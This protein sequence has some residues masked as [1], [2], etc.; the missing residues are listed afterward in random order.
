[1]TE[2]WDESGGPYGL[3]AYIDATNIQGM[4]DI[5]KEKWRNRMSEYK[6]L[7]EIFPDGK[8]D[9]R[10]F[11]F[12]I[13]SADSSFWFI[14]YFKT[15]ESRWHGINKMGQLFTAND[16]TWVKEYVEPKKTKKITMYKPIYKGYDYN[17]TAYKDEW[18]SDKE[19]FGMNGIVG[20]LEIEAE[21]QE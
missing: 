14:P 12:K 3:N 9:G 2:P 10:K 1:M 18:H 20:W 11:I 6:T 8:G 15:L 19:N 13:G 7:G 4:M 16:S 17:H 21:V 5:V